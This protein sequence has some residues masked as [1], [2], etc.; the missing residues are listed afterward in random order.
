MCRVC[1]ASL[2]GAISASSEVTQVKNPP[3]S[4][5]S[6]VDK[7]GIAALLLGIALLVLG[8]F[9]LFSIGALGFAMLVPGVFLVLVGMNSAARK[10][11]GP[12]YGQGGRSTSAWNKRRLREEAEDRDRESGAA[13]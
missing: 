11:T 7:T 5:E 4:A 12:T 6:H 2:R 8:V 10:I 9:G 3:V 1:G 13:D